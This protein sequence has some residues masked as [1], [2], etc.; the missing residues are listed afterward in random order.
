MHDSEVF[1]GV[2]LAAGQTFELPRLNEEVDEEFPHDVML[3][4]VVRP[5]PRDAGIA[6]EGPLFAVFHHLDVDVVSAGL[7]HAVGDDCEQLGAELRV[8]LE[9]FPGDG[10]RGSTA[11]ERESV[12]DERVERVR[13]FGD[14]REA[15]PRELALLFALLETHVLEGQVDVLRMRPPDLVLVAFAL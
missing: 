4:T 8:V 10:T 5:H 7:D 11:L 1:L 3:G 2:R 9:R 6:S 13:S 12:A 15:L 14:E